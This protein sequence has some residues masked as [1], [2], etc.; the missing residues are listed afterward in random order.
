[1]GWQASLAPG[2]LVT[3]DEASLALLL[4]ALGRAAVTRAVRGTD[5]VVRAQ[6]TSRDAS[7]E[8]HAAASAGTQLPDLRVPPW[9]SSGDDHLE[10]LLARRVAKSHGF[11]LRVDSYP[12]AHVLRLDIPQASAGSWL[13]A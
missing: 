6:P 3:A 13:S 2:L 11:R 8:F 4:H 9:A 5:V 10:L 1:V 12:D 7:I